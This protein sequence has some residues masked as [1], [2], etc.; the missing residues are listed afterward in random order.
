MAPKFSFVP[1]K[2]YTQ[3]QYTESSIQVENED[4]KNHTRPNQHL[5]PELTSAAGL[6]SIPYL[7]Q[8]ED[9]NVAEKSLEE[10]DEK[11]T[12]GAK[13]RQ[14]AES[15]RKALTS[16]RPVLFD[17][18][19]MSPLDPAR[20]SSF[21]VAFEHVGSC[22]IFTQVSNEILSPIQSS[23]ALLVSI[24]TTGSSPSIE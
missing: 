11:F 19:A 2:P 20:Q 9:M 21:L 6:R 1:V 14:A 10:W 18:V 5:Q 3:T 13:A 12:S 16:A 24:S 22:S 15:R 23:Y 4:R 17:H 8:W 7:G